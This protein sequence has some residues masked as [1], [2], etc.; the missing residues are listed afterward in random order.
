[1]TAL[2]S[3]TVRDWLSA[4]MGAPDGEIQIAA[5][6]VGYSSETWLLSAPDGANHTRLVVRV[7]AP[8][9]GIF[10]V[11]RLADEYAA[12]QLLNETPVRVPS[13]VF[14][15]AAT[16]N[17]FGR[18]LFAMEFVEGWVPT[19]HPS[20]AQVG[21]LYDLD[22]HAQRELQIDLITQLAELRNI[23]PAP[24]HWAKLGILG[25][26]DSS[27]LPLA[28]L[29]AFDA[30]RELALGAGPHPVVDQARQLLESEAPAQCEPSIS[31][32]D[33]KVSNVL[34]G[35][36]NTVRA[37]LDWE[38]LSVADGV[39]DLAFYL[40][41]HEVNTT[42]RGIAN[43][44]G[45]LATPDIVKVYE[46]QSGSP[47]RNLPYYRLW[48]AYRL[49]VLEARLVFMLEQSG[50]MRVTGKPKPGMQMLGDELSRYLGREPI[51]A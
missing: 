29:R 15:S 45:F 40:V 26:A 5:P 8:D 6:E 39:S 38:M 17:P 20:Y 36:D 32:G 41:F 23:R 11:S 2:T 51:H 48:A 7:A 37:L 42:R 16:E 14:W 31:W 47:V 46:Q 4:R 24:T 10:P 33:V 19:D 18:D 28:N 44:P 22:A 34:F 49:A 21:P 25:C 35:K 9:N 50:R 1:M 12:L 13:P 30:V 43:L 3:D 27:D